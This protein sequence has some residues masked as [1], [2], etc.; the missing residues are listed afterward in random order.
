MKK[1]LQTEEAG[2]TDIFETPPVKNPFFYVWCIFAKIFCFTLF[3]A[4]SLVLGIIALPVMK[5][6]WPRKKD[7]QRHSRKLVSALFKFFVFIMTASGAFCLKIEGKEVLSNLG[8]C[9]VVA[10]HP[11]LLDVVMLVSQIPN[12]DCIVNASLKKN[13]V[14][15]VVAYL[16]ITNDCEHEQMMEKC[17]STIADGNALIIFPEGTRSKPWG[18]NPYKK[19]AARVA[20][21][22][23]C[24]V[25]PVFFGGND[26]R[27]LRKKDPMLMFNTTDKYRYHLYVKDFIDSRDYMDLPA[28]AAAKRMTQKMHELLCYENNWNYILG[29]NPLL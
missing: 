2:L 11:S 28:P 14:S 23:G 9:V 25:V 27:G 18:Q 26:K 8:G 5:L 4:G 19:G 10:N 24:P 15:A 6:L 12:A 13:I 17:R 7:F 21:A 29:K 1:V 3:G 16:Y 20:L 22:A